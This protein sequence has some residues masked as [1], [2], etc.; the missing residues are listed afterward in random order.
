VRVTC[1]GRTDA[2]VHATG[3]VAHFDTA[4]QRPE[5]AWVL[6]TNTHLPPVVSVLWSRVVG[7]EFHARFSARSRRYRY[8]V[9]NR[10]VRPA[11]GRGRITWEPRPLDAERMRESAGF[12]L[13]RHDFSAF[14]SSECQ[15]RNPV[16]TVHRLDV[17]R[18]GRVIA[19]EVV[20]NAFLHHMVR[21]IAGVLMSVGAG[22]QPPRW[23]RE[24][25]ESRDRTRGG[26]TAP[27]DGL[28]LTGVDYPAGL[29]VP[30]PSADPGPLVS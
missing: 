28:Y 30:A 13:G 9:L 23:A 27:P 5:R 15:A 26:V 20:A 1:A 4:A 18:S 17:T 24:V 29:G 25:L 22:R 14:R 16:R 19:V 8:L 2:G 6:G 12:L 10:R 11:L 3:Q 21:N 7:D